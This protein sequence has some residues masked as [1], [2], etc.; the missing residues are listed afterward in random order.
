MPAVPVCLPLDEQDTYAGFGVGHVPASLVPD[1]TTLVGR[2]PVVL[3]S[4]TGAGTVLARTYG[5][6]GS[7]RRSVSHAW[8]TPMWCSEGTRTPPR[9]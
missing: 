1:L 8:K 3:V 2:L 4:G 6:P 7:A 5:L 9:A